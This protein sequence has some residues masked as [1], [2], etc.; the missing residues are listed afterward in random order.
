MVGL[1]IFS[2]MVTYMEGT[3]LCRHKLLRPIEITYRPSF[4]VRCNVLFAIQGIAYIASTLAF[5][6]WADHHK[7]L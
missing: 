5:T 4:C 6:D 2:R 7:M 3:L 1:D